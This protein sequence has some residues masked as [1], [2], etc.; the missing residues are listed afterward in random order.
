MV[1]RGSSPPLVLYPHQLYLMVGE[2]YA[3]PRSASYVV[4]SGKNCESK[5]SYIGASTSHERRGTVVAAQS[6]N[7]FSSL[8]RCSPERG[9][10]RLGHNQSDCYAMDKRWGGRPPE[11]GEVVGG[12]ASER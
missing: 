11:V 12:S 5:N 6:H 2:T 7:Q 4:V 9:M 3:A 8:R 10:P 1:V